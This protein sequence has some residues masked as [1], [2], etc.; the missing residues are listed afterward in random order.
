MA[1]YQTGY[2]FWTEAQSFSY[3]GLFEW[4]SP[5]SLSGAGTWMLSGFLPSSRIWWIFKRIWKAVMQYDIRDCFNSS[6]TPYLPRTESTYFECRSWRKNCG[7]L[8]NKHNSFSPTGKGLPQLVQARID[9]A[10]PHRIWVVRVRKL[11]GK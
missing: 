3:P 11:R 10:S 9:V 2:R 8:Q 5:V 1:N 7:S 6:T 4:S